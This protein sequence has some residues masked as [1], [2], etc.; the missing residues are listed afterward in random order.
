MELYTIIGLTEYIGEKSSDYDGHPTGSDTFT[1]YLKDKEGKIFSIQAYHSIG[2][3]GSGYCGASWGDLNLE[4]QPV[5]NLEVLTHTVEGVHQIE[6]VNGTARKSMLDND[7]YYDAVAEIVKTTDGL[8]VIGSTGNGGCAYYP[9]G[10]GYFSK[11]L[12]IKLKEAE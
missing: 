11:D 5:E 3:C 12:F 1:V 10:Y 8:Q 7:H 4:L 9:S 6:V 2:P